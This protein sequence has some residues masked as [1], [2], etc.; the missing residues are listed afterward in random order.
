MVFR[1][2]QETFSISESEGT[3][4]MKNLRP[5]VTLVLFVLIKIS[6]D[7]VY[8]FATPEYT[9][10]T[11]TACE[12]FWND[13]EIYKNTYKKIVITN[14]TWIPGPNVIKTK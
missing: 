10:G 9:T 13:L 1:A 2:G 3:A 8:L 7:T 4:L 14:K 11:D 12:A 6:G 5:F